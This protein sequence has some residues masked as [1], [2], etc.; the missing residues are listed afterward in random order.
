D[1]PGSV[2][3]VVDGRAQPLCAR[4]SPHDLERARELAARGERSVRH[5]AAQSDV[6]LLGDSH[7]GHV[8]TPA[9]FFDV[10]DPDDLDR[11]GLSF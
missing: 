8:A 6:T 10:D 4:W 2:V 9:T 3:P 11:L 7:W 5:V 1:A